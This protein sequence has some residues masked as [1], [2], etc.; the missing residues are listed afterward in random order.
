MFS[1]N[2]LY[3][4]QIKDLQ[5]NYDTNGCLKKP[6]KLCKLLTEIASWGFF[7][8]VIWIDTFLSTPKLCKIS[9][10]TMLIIF[11]QKPGYANQRNSN[12]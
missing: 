3:D 6:M 9:M 10:Q 11:S 4:N 2:S 5:S 12:S 7:E 8:P 1:G